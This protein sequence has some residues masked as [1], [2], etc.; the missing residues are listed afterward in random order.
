M[1]RKKE[2]RK[3]SVFIEPPRLFRAFHRAKI[4][5]F[6]R[7]QEGAPFPLPPLCGIPYMVAPDIGDCFGGVHS[8]DAGQCAYPVLF[9]ISERG[10]E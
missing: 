10:F 5:H 3:N 9:Q 1:N 8:H 4:L 7:G 6:A 2:Q